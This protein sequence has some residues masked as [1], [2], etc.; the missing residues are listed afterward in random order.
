MLLCSHAS[1]V[2]CTPQLFAD[3]VPRTAENFRQLC[4]GEFRKG[5]KPVGYKGC[6]FHRVIKGFMVQGGDFVK[7][8]GTGCQSIYGEKFD[9]ENFEHKHTAPG[10]LS[11]A[12]SGPGT[13]GCQ[14]FITCDACDWLDNKHVV[15][16][17]VRPLTFPRP[18][19]GCSAAA[20]CTS[21]Q[22]IDGMLTV[23]KVENV[24]VGGNS[25]PKLPIVV[26]GCG[27]M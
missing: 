13:N 14:F 25:K 9:D 18:V 16:G 12:N 20:V 17:K 21:V 15:F 4:T 11:M 27:E 3:V 10:L 23:R 2:R 8:D 22:V 1:H 5:G 26:S 19:W 24:M 7:N 6:S